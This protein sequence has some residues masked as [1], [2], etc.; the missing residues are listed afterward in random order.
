MRERR[1]VHSDCDVS[2]CCDGS[3]ARRCSCGGRSTSPSSFRRRCHPSDC[4]GRR[5]R[6]SSSF[7][8]RLRP[9]RWRRFERSRTRCRQGCCWRACALVASAV[10]TVQSHYWSVLPHQTMPSDKLPLATPGVVVAGL[11]LVY[12]APSSRLVPS[13]RADDGPLGNEHNLSDRSRRLRAAGALRRRRERQRAV[14]HGR[15]LPGREQRPD[16]RLEL[17]GDRALS[18]R[19]SASASVEP[20]IVSRLCITRSEVDL[21]PRRCRADR[22]GSG[23]R[24]SRATRGCAG[25]SRRRRCRG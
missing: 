15:D 9:W 24:A 7:T 20:V 19:R 25:G 5:A 11:W 21:G 6:S 8:A 12:S 2:W 17:S 10:A 22:S 3:C 14:D 16:L 1:H 23:G 18:L 4:V 13:R